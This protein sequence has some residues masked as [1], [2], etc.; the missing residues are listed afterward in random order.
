MFMDERMMLSNLLILLQNFENLWNMYS[1][2]E[3]ILYRDESKRSAKNFLELFCRVTSVFPEIRNSKAIH[4]NTT[5]NNEYVNGIIDGLT[6]WAEGDKIFPF[7]SIETSIGDNEKSRFFLQPFFMCL[8]AYLIG[9]IRLEIRPILCKSSGEG[10]FHQRNIKW[11]GR[12]PWQIKDRVD[13][14]L[15]SSLSESET[16]VIVGDIRKSQELIT[17]SVAP[18]DYRVKM[19]SYIEKVRGIILSKMGI[20]D[21]F[22]GDGFICYF[23][24]YLARMFQIDL[25]ATVVDVCVQIQNE[26]M[27]FFEKWQ[28]DLQKIP[29]DTIG[30]SI[31][32]DAGNID[33]SDDIMIFAIGVPAVW[34]T[35]M[36]A[37]GNAGDIVFNNIP[38]AKIV[39]RKYNYCFDEVISSTKHGE[40][41]KAFKLRM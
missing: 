17:Y 6:S 27:L 9:K 1:V 4:L 35:R 7:Y 25:Y 22:T 37:A 40:H 10:A 32:V 2:S 34:A 8:S 39:E 21:R 41:F 5:D 15:L 12:F 11:D 31:G 28:L 29:S 33:F 20:F 26:S 23:N 36:C 16:I 14:S 13:K 38:H 19:V 18:H 24:D 3:G 30:L